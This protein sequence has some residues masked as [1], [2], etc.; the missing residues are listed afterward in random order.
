MTRLIEEI[1][2]L[3]NEYNFSE[4]KIIYDKKH[5]P[6]KLKSKTSTKQFVL[7]ILAFKDYISK[8]KS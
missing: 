4:V 8:E 5:E 6:F 1:K 7:K 2:K 3:L